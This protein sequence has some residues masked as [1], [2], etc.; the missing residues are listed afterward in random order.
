MHKRTKSKNCDFCVLKKLCLFKKAIFY[1]FL[2]FGQFHQKMELIGQK[3]I[4]LSVQG[5]TFYVNP[6][7]ETYRE[8][9]L[10]LNEGFP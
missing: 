8:K 7:F 1:I 4:N 3:K 5:G 9:T 6:Y 2:I 10:N